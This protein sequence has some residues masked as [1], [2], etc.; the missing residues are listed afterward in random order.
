[1]KQIDPLQL[2]R[3]ELRQLSAYPVENA[4]GLVKLDAMENPF[5]WPVEMQTKWLDKINHAQLN[6]Y[7]EPNP[8]LI[9]QKLKVVWEPI[10]NMSFCLIILILIPLETG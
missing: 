10:T 3:T 7:P 4:E 8:Q 9:K 1:M 5:T 6:R 2:I